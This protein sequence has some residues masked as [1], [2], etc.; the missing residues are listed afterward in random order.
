MRKGGRVFSAGDVASEASWLRG[1]LVK[2]LF[3]EGFDKLLFVEG[4]EKER[5]RKEMRAST[6]NDFIIYLV[7]L[8]GT[9]FWSESI[10]SCQS[11][12]L[13]IVLNPRDWVKAA[14]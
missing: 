4:F 10:Q 11:T 6:G 12:P 7:E 14:T 1:G 3:V 8:F 9:L 5:E 13:G 2:L